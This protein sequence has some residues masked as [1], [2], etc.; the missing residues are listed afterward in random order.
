MEGLKGR[1]AEGRVL[2]ESL[3]GVDADGLEAKDLLPELLGGVRGSRACGRGEEEE[4]RLGF[5]SVW[6]EG[7]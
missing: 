1:R 6:L 4:E 3:P 7:E 2:R 5:D